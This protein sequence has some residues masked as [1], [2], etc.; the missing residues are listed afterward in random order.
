MRGTMK[1]WHEEIPYRFDEPVTAEIFTEH[2]VFFDIETTGFSPAHTSLY[3]IGC[4]SRRGD[5]LI[6]DQ[7]FAEKTI[8]EKL[9]LLSFINQ[10]EPCDTIISF[11]GSGFDIPYLKAKCGLLGV[12]KRFLDYAHVDIYKVV[13]QLKFLLKTE[14]CKQKSIEQFLGIRRDDTLSGGDLIDVYKNYL[15]QPNDEALFLLRQHNYDDITGLPALLPVLAYDKILCGHYAVT[16]IEG[17]ETMAQNGE[18]R[19]ELLITLTNDYPAPKRVSCGNALFYL[20]VYKDKTQI[21]VKLFDGELKFF[22]K[23]YKNYY[24]LPKE[25]AAVHKSLSTYVDKE[26]R[27]PAT[28]QNCYT[29]KRALFVPQYREVMKPKFVEHYRDKLSYFELTED[30]TASDVMLRRYVKQVFDTLFDKNRHKKKA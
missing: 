27:E 13:S 12:K 15:N 10:I 25:D 26:Y 24:Y 2:I 21:N 22:F 8:E 23:D 17:S 18:P 7:F 29:K 16:S 9:L 14:N 20:S 3:M 5:T 30:F 6:V 4:V 1:T 19:K 28:A 11:N